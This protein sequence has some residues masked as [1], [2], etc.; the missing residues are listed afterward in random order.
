MGLLEA[1]GLAKPASSGGQ[2]AAPKVVA[3]ASD[4]AVLQATAI[5]FNATS[6]PLRLGN[7]A[8][9][10]QA[11]VWNRPTDPI[12][13]NA[14]GTVNVQA[15]DL[16]LTWGDVDYET[17]KDKTQTEITFSWKGRAAEIRVKGPGK[18]ATATR[19]RERS[20]KHREYLLVLKETSKVKGPVIDALD[21]DVERIEGE[22]DQE[23]RGQGGNGKD[24]PATGQAPEFT[25]FCKITLVNNA[26][27]TL[28]RA[29]T[30]LDND[31]AH[32]GVEPPAALPAGRSAPFVVWSRDPQA[33]EIGGFADY[34]FRIDP[35]PDEN[36]SGEFTLKLAWSGTTSGSNVQPH[37]KGID[38]K[39]EGR[40][41]HFV[42][43]LTGRALEFVPPKPTSQPTLRK[44]DK[45]PDGWVEYL[46][47]LLNMKNDAGLDVDGDFGKLTR[48]AVIAY[49]RKLKKKDK[50][51]LDDGVVGDQ[52]WSYLRE[53]APAKPATDKRKPHTYVDRGPDA[54]WETEQTFVIYHVDR[55]MLTLMA[56]SVGD[57]DQIAGRAA[58][59]RITGPDKTQKVIDAL[60]GKG[61]KSSKT[62]QG[63]EH[64]VTIETVSDL[65]GG[66][67]LPNGIYTVE[68]YFPADIGG[69]SC[70]S[71]LQIDPSPAEIDMG[72]S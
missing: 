66:G 10:N 39:S 37:T 71:T 52:T 21:D 11:R 17:G 28:V 2:P 9:S 42:F 59:V 63:F 44:G 43:T 40:P 7:R 54:R 3:E 38:I 68:A 46:Q 35:P 15:D 1:L 48:D 18:F 49:Q 64:L 14:R 69:D 25:G 20:P 33:P 50:E 70:S 8:F 22:L 55:D 29:T 72:A 5:I 47:Q 30:H 19:Y 58:R 41:G 53:G 57:T 27:A 34:T 62:G 12:A 26:D 45:S 36:P 6:T 31:K 13:P 61:E 32:F 24:Q 4:D 60:I 65:F 16:E 23:R 56:Y 51:V 67:R